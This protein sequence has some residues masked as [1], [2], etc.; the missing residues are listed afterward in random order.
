MTSTVI[1]DARLSLGR[2]NFHYMGQAFATGLGAVRDALLV[3]S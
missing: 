2:V 3:I 1:L